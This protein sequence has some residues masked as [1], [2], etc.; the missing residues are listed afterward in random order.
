MN[1]KIASPGA[2]G[3]GAFALTTFLLNLVNAEIVP[4]A[5][6]GMVLPM[7]LFYGGLAQLLAGMW[8]FKRGDMFGGTCFSSYG[9]FWMGL[10]TMVIMEG[11]GVLAPV[12]PEGMAAFLVAWGIFSIIATVAT[13]KL[14]KALVFVF[15]TL[16]ALFFLLAIGETHHTAHVV[17]GYVGLVCALGA[18]YTAAAGLL[19]TIFKREVLPVGS[20]AD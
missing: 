18:W 12:P 13:F 8:D 6:L 3:L 2:L 19:N 5:S 17:G 11:Q 4:A 1:E 16:V 15:V 14:S 7:G 20:L 9:A 10:A